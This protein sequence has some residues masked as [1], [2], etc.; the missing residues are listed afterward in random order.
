MVSEKDGAGICEEGVGGDQIN[1]TQ[2]FLSY[3]RADAPR[4]DQI[5]ADLKAEGFNVWLDRDQ[6]TPGDL[7]V[8]QIEQAI[9]RADFL[10][11]FISRRSLESK[12]AMNEYKV[13]FDSLRQTGGTR[14]IPVLLEGVGE[15]PPFLAHIQYADFTKSYY[16][17]MQSLIRALEQP[18][19]PKP[20]E[21]IDS[22]KLAVEVAAQVVKILGLEQPAT[23]PTKKVRDE[24]L[25]FVIMAFVP[26]M[27]PI[28]EGIVA[29]A[30]TV[31]LTAKRVKDVEGDYK[32]TDKII[33]MIHS[34]RL[35]V[36][37]LTHERPNVYFELGYA[38]G[39]GKTVITIARKDSKIH[40]DVKDWKYLE[41]VDSRVL[42]RDLRKRFEYEVAPSKQ[43]KK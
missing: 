17:G 16:A 7:W 19:G 24:N 29:A 13:A 34:A 8:N 10:V 9:Q 23:L 28:F 36:A 26:D 5:A 15:L 2:V 35:I 31:K 33:E 41:Y 14:I 37:D 42:E 32:I 6:L 18:V 3:A 43:S 39:L 4:V 40:F 1:M 22:N 12:W 20:N 21:I 25:V 38:R 30:K 27:E 11:F